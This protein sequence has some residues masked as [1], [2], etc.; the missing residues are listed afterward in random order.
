[1]KALLFG[2]AVLSGCASFGTF[3]GSSEGEVSYAPEADENLKRGEAALAT[4]N[5]VDAA[6]YFEYV[7]TKYPFAEASKTAELAL[8]DTDYDRERFIEA[9]DR[10]QNFVRLHPT[11]PKVDYAAWRAAYTHVKDIPSDFFA[12]PPSYEKDQVEVRSAV[13]ALSDFIRFYPESQF[14]PEAKQALV[15]VR[16]RLAKHELY[17]A[18]FYANRQR[19]PAVVGRLSVAAKNYSGTG[20][21][22]DVYLGLSNAYLKLNDVTRARE[23]LETLV[24]LAPDSRGAAT[25]KGLLQRLPVPPPLPTMPPDAGS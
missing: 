18:D 25:A 24:A 15:D 6:K 16:S 8:A 20:Y 9:R 7:K 3:M 5:H 19:W 12:L 17:V 10:Y 14:V 11:H 1:M 13:T 23:A 4:K 21:D 22:S 2:I